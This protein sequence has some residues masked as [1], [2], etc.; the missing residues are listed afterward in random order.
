MGC[1]Q[2]RSSPEVHTGLR[3][4]PF[5]KS[6]M[7][8]G[9]L[10][11]W[12]HLKNTLFFESQLILMGSEKGET[13]RRKIWLI[14]NAIKL[15]DKILILFLI[16]VLFPLIT[17]NGWIIW[18]MKQGMNKEQDQRIENMADRLEFELSSNISAQL[19]IADYLNRNTRLKQFLERE[20]TD[21]VAYY[22]AYVQL[23]DDQVI[24]YYYTAQSAY[25]I[26][27]CTGNN[28]I[29]NGT[30]FICNDTVKD[31]SWYRAFE[32]SGRNILLYSYYEDGRE[33]GGYISKGRR[34]VLIQKLN[35]CGENNIIMLELDYQSM[36][37]SMERICDQTDGYLC[38][39]N[40]IL[41]S[42]RD[43]DGR[44][45][46]FWDLS[47]YQEK[48][49]SLQ[50]TM[51]LYGQELSFYLTEKRPA[52]LDMIYEQKKYILLLYLINLLLPSLFIYI[53]YRSLHD[54]V[55]LTQEYLDRVKEGSYEVIPGDKG[56]DEIGAMIH[57]Y[58]LM[59]MRIKELI[60][61]VFKNKEREQS[62]EIAKKQAELRALQSQLN[63]HFIFNALESIRMH[64]I[65][66][67]ETE[68][69]RI[70]ENFAVLMRK[71]IQWNRDLVT[72]EEECDNVRRYLEI[73]KYRFGERLEFFLHVQEEC[74]KRLIPKFIIIT[75]V[76]NACV[77][78]I[79]NSLE[80]GSVTVMV[81][82][83]E[84]FLYFEIMDQGSGMERGELE[85]LKKMIQ[86][87]DI[88]YIKEAEKSIGIVNTVVRMHQ[89]YGEKVEIDINS[90]AQEGTEICIQLPRNRIEEQF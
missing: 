50:R 10:W 41:F 44:E 43:K 56:I 17:T 80:G 1:P 72:I 11:L 15:R 47:A 37:E 20:Y 6:G 51:E 77:H 76:E 18:S 45:K 49:C 82:E 83:D 9:G 39:G 19:S 38:I 57:S 34:V 60:E 2:S 26:V 25:N 71:N 7:T 85:E 31:S 66:K 40:R 69:A 4:H 63:P 64:S 33:S 88:R 12:G 8:S 52:A 23:M 70:L 59:V 90:A 55:A 48:E 75:F 35:Y 27:I 42:T 54:R 61:V 14:A 21:K 78:G 3:L 16:C 28:T 62:L 65:L 89:Y 24:Q 53:F 32:E 86:E 73:Q 46:E 67:Q 30:Y 29:T 58:N 13:L 36:L 87:A 81:S 68:T 84:E 74:Q 79:E 22:E 5:Q